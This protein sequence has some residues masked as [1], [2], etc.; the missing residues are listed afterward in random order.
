[1]GRLTPVFRISLGLAILTCS[2]L[3]L[4]DLLGV[5]PEARNEALEERIKIVES[6]ALQTIPAVE[7]DDF[8][9]IRDVLAITVS[10]NEEVLSA[11]LRTA[12]GRLLISTTE[13]RNLW[14]EDPDSD[15]SAAQVHVPIVRSG[16]IWASLEVRFKGK[17]DAGALGL[18]ASLWER[19]LIRLLLLVGGLGF[20]SYWIYMRRTLKHLDPSAVI[21]TR[22]QAALDVMSEGVLLLDPSGRIVLANTAFAERLGKTPESLLGTQLSALDWRSPGSGASQPDYPW[23]EAIRE[24]RTTTGTPL[25]IKSENGGVLFFA[26]NVSPVLDGWEKP[27]GAIATFD[28][29]TELEQQ[30]AALEKAMVELEKSRDEIRLQNAEL[31]VL[32]KKDPLTGLANRRSFMEWFE[33]QFANARTEG[34][35]LQCIMADIDHFKLVNDTHGH[36]AGDEVI[37]RVSE[38]LSSAV[39]NSDAVCRY[40]GEEFCIVLPG[41]S[42]ETAYEVA[43]RLCRNA[44]SPGFARIP[45]SVSFGTAS[46]KSGA[47][48]IADLLE[49]ADRALY[50]SK[51]AGRDRVTAWEDI[52]G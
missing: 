39:R 42:K 51:D 25:S 3:V 1:V 10:R 33:M 20:A 40:G 9:S 46:I 17:A 18:F 26:V 5:L 30:K 36:A 48:G 24:G 49:Q 47:G 15:S 16:K 23:W 22:V 52:S 7:R 29:V 8:G 4:I 38:L 50:A 27:K 34:L 44:R 43:D 11:G 41:A 19:T 12:R 45:L 14:D 2:I 6:L 31:E 32:A 13:H 37:R 28:D 21:P 35:D